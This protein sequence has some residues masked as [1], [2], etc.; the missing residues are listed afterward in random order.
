MPALN[1]AG[2]VLG[3]PLFQRLVII[4]F[5]LYDFAGVRI[6]VS[7]QLPRFT[8]VGCRSRILTALAAL[9]I[10]QIDNVLQAETILVQQPT[11]LGLELVFFLQTGVALQGFQSL[12]LLI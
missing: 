7:L 10:Q 12:M 11:Q 5:S 4:T 8:S 6:F 2:A 9:R 1:F 3:F